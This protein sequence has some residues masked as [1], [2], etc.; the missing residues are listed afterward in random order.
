MAIFLS[1]L[2]QQ[3]IRQVHNMARLKN[4]SLTQT[5]NQGS[6]S[7]D[8]EKY[9]TISGSRKKI[10]FGKVAVA[11]PSK[12][13]ITKEVARV[14]ISVL[15]KEIPAAVV[16]KAWFVASHLLLPPHSKVLDAGCGDGAMTY[17]MAALRPEL[18]FVGIDINATKIGA[19]QDAYRLDNL[20]YDLGNIYTDLGEAQYDAIINSF[21]LHEIY[22]DSYFNDRM[23]ELALQRQYKALKAGG[24]MVIRDHINPDLQKFI[25]IEFSDNAGAG[26]EFDNCSESDLLIWY[27]EHARET[28]SEDQSGGDNGFFLEELP[29]NFPRMRLFRLPEK[30]A[31]EFLWRKDDRALLRAEVHKEYAFY[32]ELEFA[33]HFSALGARLTYSA[34]HWDEAFL[35][36]RYYGKI[37]LYDEDGARLGPPPTNHIMVVHKL[38]IRSAQMVQERRASRQKDGPIHINTVRNDK[39]GAISDIISRNMEISEIIPFRVS[40]EGRLKI[41]LQEFVP[42]GLANA[43]PR[44]G[45]ILD[46]RK[47]SG[48]MIEAIATASDIVLQAKDKSYKELHKFAKSY[49]GFTAS[50]DSKLLEGGGFFPDPN[51]IDERILTHYFRVEDYH[52]PFE[53]LH[54]MHD[55]EGFSSHPLVRE[56]D[57]QDVLNAIA[58]GYIPTSRL[59]TQILALFQLLGI[60]AECWGDMPVQLSE[61]LIEETLKITDIMK[62]YSISDDR[63]K[64]VRGQ[65]GQVR[66]IQSVFVEEGR[67][68]NGTIS[69]LSARDMQFAVEEDHTINTAVVL[70]LV[71]NLNGEVMAGVVTQYLPVPQRY[72]STG[73]SVTLPS[74]NLPKDVT[75]IEA[76]KHYI[77]KQYN[78]KP[79][80]VSRM[81]E[82]YFTH[83]GLMPHRIYPFVVTNFE[84]GYNGHAH[85]TT[86]FTMLRELWKLLYWD[87]HDS[88]MKIAGMAY[89]NLMDSDVSVRRGFDFSMQKQAEQSTIFSSE[90]IP[91]FK[92]AHAH[93]DDSGISSGNTSIFSSTGQSY[94]S[95]SGDGESEGGNGSYTGIKFDAGRHD[96]ETDKVPKIPKLLTRVPR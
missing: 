32:G 10:T 15:L 85:G 91:T 33:R 55:I 38:S 41:Y 5:L 82:S 34:P 31:Y 14:D 20:S 83:I 77:A 30:W 69:G 6:Q 88:F 61:L 86:S 12:K 22:S 84:S 81:G 58:V 67:E 2:D 27:S 45:R 35:K 78:V 64:P 93:H 25:Q 73:H 60:R 39:N 89:Q 80:Y 49:L 70:P 56:F 43:V 66:M 7:T 24:V 42:R 53:T 44:H 8:P 40:E 1:F 23:I 59:E 95:S 26:E 74:F 79:E 63:Y 52:P 90:A 19:A 72:S 37:R 68:A 96:P 87:N 18:E 29:P 54:P 13:S 71:K 75:D 9:E 21:F 65:A 94:Q 47:W 3:E 92:S 36:S 11:K 76:A 28:L 62:Q 16:K 48:H 57:A 50:L 46:G 51:R 4:S 17:A